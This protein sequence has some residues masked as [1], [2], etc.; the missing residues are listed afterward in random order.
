MTGGLQ[1][2]PLTGLLALGLGLAGCGV[3]APVPITNYSSAAL[4]PVADSQDW[5]TFGKTRFKGQLANGAPDGPGLCIDIESGTRQAVACSYV[6]GNR[7][8]AAYLADRREA[9]AS[10]QRRKQE[11]QREEDENEARAAAYRRAERAASERATQ[12]AVLANLATLQQ[13]ARQ[14]QDI[15][16]STAQAIAQS[17]QAQAD[18]E[19]QRQADLKA[20]RERERQQAADD[21][22]DV[23]RRSENSQRIAQ[24][25]RD[26]QATQAARA[27]QE[28][29][30]RDKEQ[31]HREAERQRQQ[32]QRDAADVAQREAVAA[33][34]KR[35]QEKATAEAA[36]RAEKEADER[37]KRD[38]LA[39]VL[40]GTKLYAR[41]CPS[42]DGN[43]FLVGTLPNVKPEK[44]SCVDVHY[45]A[46]CEGSAHGSVGVATKFVGAATDCFFGDAV[47]ITPKPTCPVKQ[48]RVVA[49]DVK[50]C[51]S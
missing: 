48:V 26:E 43:Y 41:T 13:N 23:Q 36:A 19:A 29:A 32:A 6:R 47:T 20:R 37:A 50:V 2:A 33:A 12:Q 45:E 16:R 49:R 30:A 9:I 28:Q 34:A 46:I 15:N 18:R 44:V 8:D 39:Q 14:M 25:A 22:A 27:Q 11:Q 38:Y 1:R 35:A 10:E 40:S 42:G 7:T 31:Q 51:G 5:Y 24:A 3:S 21:R 4:A 17:D